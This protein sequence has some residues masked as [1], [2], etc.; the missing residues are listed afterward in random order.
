[1][2]RIGKRQYKASN[3][4]LPD[5]WPYFAQRDVEIMWKATLQSEVATRVATIVGLQS[6]IIDL[7]SRLEAAAAANDEAA[8]RI[9]TVHAQ[10]GE[11]E[12]N[13]AALNETLQQ[14]RKQSEEKLC[15]LRE[16]RD[17]MTKEFKLLATAVMQQHGETF[18]KQNK[19]QI[20]VVLGPLREKLT[21]FQLGLSAAHTES[22]KERATLGEQIKQLAAASTIMTSE[23]SNLT[24]ALK[25]KAQ[26]QGAWG[27][28][29]LAK[30]LENC[31]LR[32][33]EEYL[34]QPSHTTEN[35][36]RLR[37]DVIVN[38]PNGHRIVIDAKVSLTA[39]AAHVNAENEED[40]ASCLQRHLVSMRTHIKTLGDKGYQVH[41]NDCV[42]YVIMFVPIE[43]ALALALNEAPDMTIDALA[44]NVIIATP[45]T[46]ALALRTAASVWQ[47]ERR[48]KNAEAI[49][50]RAGQLY[51][52]FVGFTEDMRSLGKRLEQAQS[53]YG[54][55]MG[56]LTTGSGNLLRQADMLKSL[57]AKTSKALLPDLLDGAEPIALPPAIQV[58]H[59]TSAD[60]T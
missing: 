51:D 48:N 32:Q 16:A 19:E 42:D 28:M 39:Y 38:L 13:L 56:K 50:T 5:N 6:E 59:P 23:T 30:I 26:T 4:C 36:Q 31:G 22:L 7:R 33:G 40:R 43:G 25:G 12:A 44:Q 14:E 58:D 60:I 47:D 52:K 11:L 45:T 17:D 55:A 37:P 54:E 20:A 49:A 34:T 3:I 35:G 10:K 46:L 27:E 2:T 53:T 41:I 18:S 57:G 8:L 24:R 21:E 29:V 9:E 1:M 15:L